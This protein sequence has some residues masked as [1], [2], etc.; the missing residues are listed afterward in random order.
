MKKNMGKV[1]RLV[2]IVA[3]VVLLGLGL[4]TG[5]W[6]RYLFYALAVIMAVTSAVGVCPLYYPLRFNTLGKGKK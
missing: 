4:F 6:L 2:R 3:A 1:D 5:S